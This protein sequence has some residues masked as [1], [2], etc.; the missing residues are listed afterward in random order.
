M[1]EI[2]DQNLYKNELES[3]IV[4]NFPLGVIFAT[5]WSDF[6]VQIFSLFPFSELA[7]CPKFGF[8]DKVAVGKPLG[9]ILN[10]LWLIFC[11]VLVAFGT[12]CVLFETDKLA[13]LPHAQARIL[14]HLGCRT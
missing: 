2:R 12:F 3:K 13:R 14:R 11:S 1:L 9:L 5:I 6:G 7:V 8:R 4:F 10:H